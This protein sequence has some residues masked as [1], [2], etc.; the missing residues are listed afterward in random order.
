[1]SIVDRRRTMDAGRRT[2]DNWSI[3]IAHR[4]LCAQVIKFFPLRVVPIFEAFKSSIYDK[5][6]YVG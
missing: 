6:K 4:A 5:G 2:T 3:R 1:M